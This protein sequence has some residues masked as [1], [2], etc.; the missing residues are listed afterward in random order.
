MANSGQDESG[1]SSDEKE[2]K[3]S[4]LEKRKQEQLAQLSSKQASVKPSQ[5]V[6]KTR[7]AHPALMLQERNMLS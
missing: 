4:L 2:D 5:Q 6:R 7:L 1:D 3:T